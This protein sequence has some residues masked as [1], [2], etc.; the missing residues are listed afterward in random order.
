[1][2]RPFIWFGPASVQALRTALAA[3]SPAARLEIHEEVHDDFTLR[4]VE[5]GEVSPE[6]GGGINESHVCP[7]L[8]P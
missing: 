3:A 7:P 8:C 4:V 6:G 2:A 1:M 5:P